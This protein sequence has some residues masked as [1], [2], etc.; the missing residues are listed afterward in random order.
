MSARRRLGS[1]SKSMWAALP[2][3][4]AVGFHSCNTCKVNGIEEGTAQ[5]KVDLKKGHGKMVCTE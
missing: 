5:R 1:S 3:A 2:T 4:L